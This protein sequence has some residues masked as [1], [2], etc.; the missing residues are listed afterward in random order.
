MASIQADSSFSTVFLLNFITQ[1][2]TTLYLYHRFLAAVI[3][4]GIMDQK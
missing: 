4:K 1:G 2:M 3:L